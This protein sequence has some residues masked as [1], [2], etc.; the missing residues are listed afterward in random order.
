[1]ATTA[2][3]LAVGLLDALDRLEVRFALFHDEASVA[4]GEVTSDLDLVVDRAP[5]EI[6]RELLPTFRQVGLRVVSHCNYDTGST[7]FFLVSSTAGG[8]VQL[9]LVFD[10]SGFGRYALK[11]DEA[12]HQAERGVRWFH[13][14]ELDE[15]IYLL[16]KRH[17][18]RDRAR[19]D[20]A[21]LRARRLGPDAVLRRGRDLLGSRSLRALEN[22]LVGGFEASAASWGL[23]GRARQVIRYARR[24][25]RPVGYWLHV[26]DDDEGAIA[27]GILALCEGALPIADAGPM[28]GRLPVLIR[29]WCREVAP[30]RWRPLLVVSQG[31]NPGW[32][33][34]DLVLSAGTMSI[35]A[36]VAEISERMETHTLMVAGIARTEIVSSG[37]NQ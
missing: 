26:I 34:P 37:A 1:M 31:H 33:A 16:F 14:C 4:V 32:P 10:P 7:A 23:G 9:D 27:G 36:L 20:D 15:V 22:L 21:L 8:S 3:E 29:W 17:L 24:L 19:F 5:G 30:A 35:D 25:R 12:L 18:K 13:L 6:I 11:T 28:P 2:P